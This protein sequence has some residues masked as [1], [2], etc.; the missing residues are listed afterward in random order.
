MPKQ[1]KIAITVQYEADT[2]EF[3]FDLP[4]NPSGSVWWNPILGAKSGTNLFGIQN[5]QR[6]KVPCCQVLK[7][8]KN[9]LGGGWVG[10]ALVFTTTCW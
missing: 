3:D 5:G 1:C 10:F 9:L 4:S 8:E 7:T 2:M 6:V